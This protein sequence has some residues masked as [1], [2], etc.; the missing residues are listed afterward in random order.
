M[1]KKRML[2]HNRVERIEEKIADKDFIKNIK[3][4]LNHMHLFICDQGIHKPFKAG[5]KKGICEYC[6]IKVE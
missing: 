4:Q 5:P 6:G 2:D 1:A 3:K